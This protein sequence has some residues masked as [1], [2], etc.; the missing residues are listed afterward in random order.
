MNLHRLYTTVYGTLPHN[1]KFLPVWLFTPLRRLIRTSAAK[2][3]PLYFDKTPYLLDRPQV[4][5]L[6]VSL[7]SFPSRIDYVYLVIESIMRQTVLPEKILLWLSLDQFPQKSALPVR[8]T[9]MQNNIFEIRFV[10]GDI[11]SHKKYYYTFKQYPKS[12]VVLI[13]DD[14]IYPEKMLENMLRAEQRFPDSVV[15]M[16]AHHMRYKKDKSIMSYA[17]WQVARTV[18]KSKD[19]F[20]GTGGGTLIK[21]YMLYEDVINRDLF[22]NLTP[23]ADDIWI[24]AMVRLGTYKD[25]NLITNRAFLPIVIKDNQS[26]YSNNVGHNQNDIQIKAVSNY[27]L[28]EIGKDPFMN[29]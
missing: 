2:R 28:G 29:H 25:I 11:K 6:I 21:P 26:L 16:Y 8:L 13:D 12:K 15:S 4:D 9:S 18:C 19:L 7:T 27:Y 20:F 23:L 5:D 1:N 24:N 22:E 10:D 17:D 14:I 3:L